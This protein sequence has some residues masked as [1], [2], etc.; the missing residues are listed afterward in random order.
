MLTLSSLLLLSQNQNCQNLRSHYQTAGCCENENAAFT[1]ATLRLPPQPFGGFDEYFTK[2]LENSPM[3]EGDVSFDFYAAGPWQVYLGSMSGGSFTPKVKLWG[4]SGYGREF[5]CASSTADCYFSNGVL[6]MI[7]GE[8]TGHVTGKVTL[9][10]SSVTFELKS[11]THNYEVTRTITDD[12]SVTTSDICVFYSTLDLSSQF[13]DGLTHMKVFSY[14]RWA[15][16]AY[17]AVNMFP[18]NRPLYM[19]DTTPLAGQLSLPTVSSIS[20]K[21]YVGGFVYQHGNDIMLTLSGFEGGVVPTVHVN[22][23]KIEIS[24]DQG[25]VVNEASLSNVTDANDMSQWG[26]SIEA[27]A[28]VV[29]TDCVLCIKKFE[30][31]QPIV[32]QGQTRNSIK[33]FS[34][35]AGYKLG[36]VSACGGACVY[37]RFNGETL[38]LPGVSTS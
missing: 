35:P 21:A 2:Q 31:A 9:T 32:A 13:G 4:E 29:S 14:N 20:D 33:L 5:K 15:T 11:T 27:D 1:P 3:K 23:M 24:D 22:K 7:I 17:D 30:N 6:N 16:D 34:V 10:A 28:I 19:Q 18:V 38:R 37:A 8:M 26:W 36:Y 12:P 25:A